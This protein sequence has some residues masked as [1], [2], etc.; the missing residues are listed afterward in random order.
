MPADRVLTEDR[1]VTVA[2]PE[3]DSTNVWLRREAGVTLDDAPTAF[4]CSNC[5]A[6]FDEA[7]VRAVK[8]KGKHAAYG[9]LSPEDVGL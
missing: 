6:A 8:A 2:C 5:A 4:R 3:C 9:D 7:I 1:R